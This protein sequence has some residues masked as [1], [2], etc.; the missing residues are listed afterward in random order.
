MVGVIVAVMSRS[1]DPLCYPEAFV[2]GHALWHL[3]GAGALWM[4]SLASE[5]V[6]GLER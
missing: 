2:Q 6:T 3:L 1:G 5:R 4:W